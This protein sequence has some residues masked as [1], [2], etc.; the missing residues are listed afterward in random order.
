MNRFTVLPLLCLVLLSG[1]ISGV[2]KAQDFEYWPSAEYD[3]SVPTAE[4]ILGYRI[5]DRITPPRGPD[6][7]P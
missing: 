3:A 1:M 6:E 2:S 5:G 4:E 7:I